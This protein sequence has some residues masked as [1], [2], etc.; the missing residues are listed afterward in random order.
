MLFSLFG[1]AVLQVNKTFA[2]VVVGVFGVGGD[3]VGEILFSGCQ[4]GFLHLHL[5]HAQII[6]RCGFVGAG[7]VEVALQ[8]SASL[9]KALSFV[10]FHAIFI[11]LSAYAHGNGGK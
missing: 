5:Y 7:F 9:S 11:T 2:H 1:V 6:V 8:K 3:A 10:E 4:I